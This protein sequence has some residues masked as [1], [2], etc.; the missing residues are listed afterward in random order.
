MVA[1]PVS[2]TD[3]E[4]SRMIFRGVLRRLKSKV[5]KV[6][7]ELHNDAETVASL[8]DRAERVFTNALLAFM[9]ERDAAK[10]GGPR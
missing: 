10:I 9:A 8:L 5:R 3:P 4:L 1:G 6:V 2:A 7:R